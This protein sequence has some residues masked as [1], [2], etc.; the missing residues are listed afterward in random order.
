MQWNGH[1]RH[2]LMG[3]SL[4]ALQSSPMVRKN[5][6]A[7]AVGAGLV[8]ERTCFA[9]CGRRWEGGQRRWLH[10]WVA[11]VLAVL[12]VAMMPAKDVE[13]LDTWNGLG[14][15]GTDSTDVAVKDLFVP[16]LNG[17]P[18]HGALSADV[19]GGE[20]ILVTPRLRTR[21]RTSCS[22][23]SIEFARRST[24]LTLVVISWPL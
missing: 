10:A 3:S 24:T 20:P 12:I 11:K 16:I 5:S 18:R 1:P 6:D 8:F 23:S 2:F 22:V 15:R 19:V 13:V 9:S 4:I 17:A 21:W 7:V 14:M